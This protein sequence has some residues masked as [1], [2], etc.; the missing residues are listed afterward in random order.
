M[1]PTLTMNA[2]ERVDTS[3][4]YDLDEVVVVAQPKEVQKLRRQ[5]LQSTLFTGHDLRQLGVND[6]SRLA[7]FVP[8]M[9]IPA[10]G[11]RLTSSTY[12][13]GIGSRTGNAAVGVYY[14][15]IPLSDKSQF[16]RHFY[17]IDRVDVLRGPQGTLYGMNAEGGLMRIYTKNPMHYQGT[18]MRLSLATGLQTDVELAHYHRPS[19]SF[20]FSTA[21]FYAGQKGFFDN[22]NLD[23]HADLSNEFGGRLRMMWQPARQWTIDFT[24]EYQY[25]NQNAFPYGEYDSQTKHFSDPRTTIVNG[26]KRQMVNSGLHLSY[27]LPSLLFSSVTSHQYLYDQMDMDQDYLPEDF[28]RLCQRQRM[29][30]ITQEFTMR[31]RGSRSWNH[32]SGVI[33]SHE[34]LKTDGPVFF[35][36]D[37][38]R[39]IVSNMGMPESVAKILTISDNSVPGHFRTPL[40]NIG[41][42][43]ESNI[44]LGAGWTATI[45]LRYDYQRA[46][47]DYATRSVFTLSG[48]GMMQMGPAIIPVKFQSSFQSILESSVAN[49]YHQLLPKLGLTWQFDDGN[50]YAVVSKG[51]RAGG[52]NIQMFSDVFSQE[53]KEIGAGFAAMMKG[54]M[55]VEHDDD[56]YKEVAETITYKPETSWNYE[57]GT[58]LNLFGGSVHADAAVYYMRVNDLQL[59]IMAGEQGLGRK[60]VNAGR[61]SS[62]GFELALRGN[63]V[64]NRLSWAATYS[65]THTSLRDYHHNYVPFIPLHTFSALADYRLGK[66][67]IGLNVSGNGKTYWDADNAYSQNLYATLGAHVGFDLGMVKLNIWGRNLTDTR[68]N[69]ML[70]NSSIDGTTRSFV[71]QG[72]PLQLGADVSLSF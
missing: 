11:S 58:H 65:F 17:Q 42:Y 39:M 13:R 44:S 41:V 23:E 36:D 57:L 45:G 28:F 46:K 38:N 4:V 55:T 16:N 66:F 12:V 31:S 64:A 26:Y 1:L 72:N 30:A 29:N 15:N 47:I 40:L 35:G 6:M 53:Q 9:S 5:P 8:S 68:Y 69:T 52:Y 19:D 22:D 2:E 21:V 20:A 48:D 10:Y 61:S 25:V 27:S 14:D 33:F 34:W 51:F 67:T 59:S 43:H 56:Y 62:C 63:A 71:Q 54:D 37:M 7:A 18:D 49:D 24:S 70:V 32:S 3:R 60:M 50:V